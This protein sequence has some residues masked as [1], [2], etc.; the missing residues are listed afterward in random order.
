MGGPGNWLKSPPP[1]R[2]RG[3]PRL[4]IFN[5]R[6]SGRPDLRRGEVGLLLATRS[7][8]QC[9]PGEGDSRRTELVERPPHPDPLPVKNGER[10]G[11]SFTSL[12]RA[13]LLDFGIAR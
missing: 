13:H 11:E 4:R 12:F 6:K 1:R 2:N 10:E 9:N 5:M 8:V 7:V 3:L